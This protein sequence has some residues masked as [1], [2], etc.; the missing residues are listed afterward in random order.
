M[1]NSSGTV[2]YVQQPGAPSGYYRDDRYVR[3]RA[4]GGCSPDGSLQCANSGAG[5]WVCDQG[6][7]VDMGMVAA[8]TEC[9]NGGIVA[10]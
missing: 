1:S 4:Y 8:G 6:G 3:Y 10:A 7:W 2:S 5:F 9:V